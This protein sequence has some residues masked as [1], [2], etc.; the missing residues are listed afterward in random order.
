MTLAIN[1]LWCVGQVK[2]EDFYKSTHE[3]MSREPEAGR[4]LAMVLCALVLLVVL[5]VLQQ[6]RRRQAAPK[7]VSHQGRLLKEIVRKLPLKQGE[8]RM[9]RQ[10]AEEQSCAS[11]LVLLLCPS[12]LARSLEGKSP[13][14]R[15]T[16]AQ[17]VGRMGQQG[18]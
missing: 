12:V 4:V 17:V 18:S 10:L 2:L 7:P 8:V 9:L 14:Q 6:R 11:P 3:S 1:G 13:A 16:I 5:V 15:Q